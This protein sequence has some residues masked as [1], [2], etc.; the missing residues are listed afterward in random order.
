LKKTRDLFEGTT[1]H[2][3]GVNEK[4]LSLQALLNA[5]LYYSA[6]FVQKERRMGRSFPPSTHMDV[7]SLKL[8]NTFQ[9]DVISV[10]LHEILSSKYII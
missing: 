7:S 4:T 6:F 5:S 10:S 3:A 1:R 9:L 8:L 2:S